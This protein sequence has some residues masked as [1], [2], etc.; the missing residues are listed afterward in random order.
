MKWARM[1]VVGSFLVAGAA[2]AKAAP[3][4]AAAPTPTW[5]VKRSQ[6]ALP[7]VLP[8][9]GAPAGSGLLRNNEFFEKLDVNG[10]GD[11]NDSLL[12]WFDPVSGLGSL[13][14]GFILN[15]HAP[16]TRG[17]YVVGF[18]RPG[19]DLNRD[20]D[21]SDRGYFW[22]SEAGRFVFAIAGEPVVFGGSTKQAAFGEGAGAVVVE[23][24]VERNVDL[25]GDG[26][27]EVGAFDYMVLPSGGVGASRTH[28]TT[29]YINMTFV[30][31]GDGS[32]GGPALV[33]PNGAVTW[34]PESVRVVAHIDDTVF[35]MSGDYMNPTVL[36]VRRADAS[37]V[38]FPQG[39]QAR[40]IG[41]DVWITATETIA[42][43][44]V[45]GDGT[46]RSSTGVFC[47]VV[48]VATTPVLSCLPIAPYDRMVP[49]SGGFALFRGTSTRSSDPPNSFH[50]YLVGPSGLVA[51]LDAEYPVALGDGSVAVV[52]HSP[53]IGTD[54]F[55]GASLHILKGGTIGPAVWSRRNASAPSVASLGDGRALITINEGI[56]ADPWAV[57]LNGDGRL[58]GSVSHLYANGGLTNL[59]AVID[60]SYYFT[61]FA[62]S[63]LR[64]GGPIV[65]GV[66]ES[67]PSRDLNGD[68]DTFDLVLQ[69][70]DGTT[71]INLGLAVTHDGNYG[72]PAPNIVG[73]DSF[74]VS[75]LET[76]QGVDL[77]GNGKVE[78]TKAPFLVTREVS[79]EPPLPDPG[80]SSGFVQPSRVLDTRVGGQVGY[81]GAKPSAGQTLEVQIAGRGGVP[82]T[83]A[84]SVALNVTVTDATD[85]GY[86]TVWG[87]GPQP[88]TSNVN[89]ERAG[90][91]VP[92][93]VVVPVG[94]DGKVRLFSDS[95][96]HLLADVAAWWGDGSGLQ[97]LKASRLLDTR[98]GSKPSP[99]ST[100][101]M[102][103][104][105]RGGAPASGSMVAVLNVTVTDATGPG[106]VTVW[107]DGKRPETSNLNAAEAGRTIAN[108][109]VVPVGADGMVHLFSDAGTH[110]LVDLTGVFVSGVAVE[111]PN[112]VLDTR[113]SA[114]PKPGSVVV[115]PLVV[116]A[117][118]R[119]VVLNVTATRATGPGY[120]TVWPDGAQPTSSNLN[121]EYADQT[122]P[123]LVIVPVG[124]DGSIRV[125]TDAGTDLIV[126]VLAR[127]T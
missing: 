114:K 119:A 84:K 30:P 103:V 36:N 123:N 42:S 7:A 100:T 89:I 48:S 115:V 106:F 44:D 101:D 72:F 33:L 118:T 45:D 53:P 47:R 79:T 83:G 8:V 90:Q 74:W 69:V 58:G 57:D 14:S 4:A 67:S 65:V 64:P 62:Y 93:L 3:A 68:N 75:V 108:L 112:R 109:V 54:Q 98:N 81:V 23:G 102:K 9:P 60:P 117:G 116:P 113:S 28:V 76:D 86:V 39:A 73:P 121:I 88:D 104:A 71:M 55:A 50:T 85:A 6:S 15:E 70:I 95:G 1:A 20:G 77:D 82:A 78:D 12:Q 80:A 59:K 2:V 122:V 120:L 26:T 111:A 126:D 66:Y 40:Q 51:T 92:N 91:T 35:F 21:S 99:G 10:D 96:A 61:H 29:Q 124:A 107:G 125:F 56:L 38:V 63:T 87:D 49:T 18:E 11:V 41:P 32:V 46:I 34:L 24:E 43:T 22:V 97:P 31:F 37:S 27:I 105:G 25:D 110:L 127:L 13:F 17:I 5:T 52:V 94:A 19:V 16:L